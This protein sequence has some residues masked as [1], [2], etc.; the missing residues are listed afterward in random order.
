MKCKQCGAEWNLP[1]NSSMKIS[2]CPFCGADMLNVEDARNIT[3]FGEFM[4]F[5][6]SIYGKEI[7][8][9]SDKIAE[10]IDKYYTGN[11]KFKRLY[12]RV[13]SE[14]NL[15]AKIYKYSTM[16]DGNRLQYYID[17]IKDL[18]E[19]NF[20]DLD[21]SKKIA[22]EFINGLSLDIPVATNTE[23]VI[24]TQ[25]IVNEPNLTG[26][27][28]L[29]KKAEAGD[30][31][32]IKK[33][34]DAYYYGKDIAVNYEEAFKWYMKAA[35]QNDGYAQFSIGYSYEFGKGTAQNYEEALKWYIKAAMQNYAKAQCN[36]G[37]LYEYGKGT[38]QNYEEALKWYMKAAMQDYARAQ[39]NLGF[40]YE[41]G[42]GTAQNYEEAFKW[43]M[44]AAM[45]N[46]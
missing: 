25:E 32:S 24:T 9:D 17:I 35:M 4:A 6:V 27:P 42:K 31:D 38:A 19:Q 37:F 7:Y 43:Y 2:K 10:L 22:N 26:L 18:S 13:V 39:C 20:F 1:E 36:L 16:Q 21:F 15:T 33:V 28:L 14:D 34:A 46:Y 11:T 29:L 44:K 3:N 8:N 40:L 23:P 5:I 45:Q 41:Y 30:L 12:M